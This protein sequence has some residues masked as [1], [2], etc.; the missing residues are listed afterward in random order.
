MFLFPEIDVF[1]FCS[2][3]PASLVPRF[4]YLQIDTIYG[5]L[6]LRQRDSVFVLLRKTVVEGVHARFVSH[7][8]R[9]PSLLVFGL[10]LGDFVGR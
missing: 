2:G 5:N 10:G 8:Y 6:F 1:F 3:R 4:Q 7:W 9:L